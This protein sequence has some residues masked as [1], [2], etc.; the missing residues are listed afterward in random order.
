MNCPICGKDKVV[1][2]SHLL[3]FQQVRDL[4]YQCTECG[5]VFTNWQQERIEYLEGLL[6]EIE[7]YSYLCCT[8][9][10][11]HGQRDHRCAVT[12]AEKWRAKE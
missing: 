3:P 11:G 4:H 2:G 1:C 10:I 9:R 5:T 8:D 12:I 6:R 7:E